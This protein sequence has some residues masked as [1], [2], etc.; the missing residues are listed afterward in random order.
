MYMCFNSHV[1]SHHV[2][3]GSLSHNIVSCFKPSIACTGI[4][5]AVIIDGSIAI[6]LMNHLAQ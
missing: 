5:V 4:E 1:P 2:D 6:D 3:V